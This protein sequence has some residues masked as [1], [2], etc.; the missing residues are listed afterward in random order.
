MLS[1]SGVE[2]E[3]ISPRIAAPSV[4]PLS[5]QVLA[6]GFDYR[7][8]SS[9]AYSNSAS[10]VQEIPSVPG[11]RDHADVAVTTGKPSQNDI[12]YSDHSTP[13]TNLNY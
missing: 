2:P 7:P 6:W 8:T 5:N 11:S 3:K 13:D 10:R 12:P 9:V 1:D 4:N